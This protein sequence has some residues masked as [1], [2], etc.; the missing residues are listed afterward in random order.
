M[1][2]RQ[3]LW[4]GSWV[5]ME[6]LRWALTHHDQCLYKKRLGDRH[7]WMK[8]REKGASASQG[9]R[10]QKEQ[11]CSHLGFR[12]PVSR[13]IIKPIAVVKVTQSGTSFT[14]ALATDYTLRVTS[15]RFHSYSSPSALVYFENCLVVAFWFC[16]ELLVVTRREE[17]GCSKL[18]P[19]W[20]PLWVQQ[21]CI[22]YISA[23][24]T[25]SKN[26]GSSRNTKPISHGDSSSA[27]KVC[28]G[29]SGEYLG[30]A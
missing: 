13:S 19:C 12:F 20:L 17:G 26:T 23:R 21:T 15:P 25:E 18:S 29:N 9:Q 2:W 28:P 3:G 30:L 16:L 7:M 1:L 4:R 10:P 22:C 5:K 11:L 27:Q 14:A 6:S 8:T 24:V